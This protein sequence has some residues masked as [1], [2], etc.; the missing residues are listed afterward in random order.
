MSDNSLAG[1]IIASYQGTG[2]TVQDVTQVFK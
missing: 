1:G 2:Q